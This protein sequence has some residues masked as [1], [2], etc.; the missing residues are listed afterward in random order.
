MS[1]DKGQTIAA[2]S[3]RLAKCKRSIS[4]LEDDRK[5]KLAGQSDLLDGLVKN[6]GKPHEDSKEAEPAEDQR[7]NDLRALAYFV[8]HEIAPDDMVTLLQ[9]V[10]PL[11]PLRYLLAIKQTRTVRRWQTNI[12]NSVRD[13]VKM[14]CDQ[15]SKD[16]KNPANMSKE[17]RF[18]QHSVDFDVMFNM[19]AGVSDDTKEILKQWANYCFRNWIHAAEISY[20]YRFLPHEDK[21]VL[22]PFAGETE[23]TLWRKLPLEDYMQ[24]T[25]DVRDMPVTSAVS[26]R[27]K[28]RKTT[29]NSD[30]PAIVTVDKA[31]C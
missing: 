15:S 17:E 12:L 9:S 3:P 21:K 1:T 19:P 18:S 23:Y 2:G 5:V 28:R 6:M 24:E 29:A 4:P 16:N 30:F 14:I 7:W 10:K 25:P 8:R 26:S 11:Q 31:D 22:E 13:R 27:A 20:L